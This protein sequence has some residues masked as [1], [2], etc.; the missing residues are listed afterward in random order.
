ML[1]HASA[2]YS[3]RDWIIFHCVDIPHFLSQS[4]FEGRFVCFHLLSFYS[5]LGNNSWSAFLRL[6]I[7][8]P[9]FTDEESRALGGQDLIQVQL[10]DSLTELGMDPSRLTSRLVHIPSLWEQI[11]QG[12]LKNYS[13]FPQAIVGFLNVLSFATFR[14]SSEMVDGVRIFV[15][16]F[17]TWVCIKLTNLC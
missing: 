12:N 5:L 3:F 15:C 6:R 11:C 8:T 14:Q 4:S 10:H 7:P 16:C 2:L 1:W 13:G 9:D 17:L